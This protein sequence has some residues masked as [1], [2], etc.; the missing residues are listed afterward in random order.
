M[1]QS[2]V[3]QLAAVLPGYATVARAADVLRLAPRS[4]RD[5]I[6]SGR[7]PSSRVGRLHYVRASDLEAERRRRLGA[8]LPRRT[9]RPVRPRT[10]ATPERPIKR[11]H[12]DPALRR[13]RAAERAEVVMRWAERHAPSNPLVPFSPVITVDRVTCASC[14]RAIHPNQRALEARESGDRLCLTCGRR[15]LM[16]WAD[17]RRLEAAAARRLAQDLGAGAETRVA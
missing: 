6:Y 2:I 3:A 8:P 9:P 13:Q 11:P 15:A 12:V 10:S 5:L 14:G 4:V 7:L 17:R 16:Q 1:L